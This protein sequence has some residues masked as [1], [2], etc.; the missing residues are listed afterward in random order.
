[1]AQLPDTDLIERARSACLNSLTAA[2]GETRTPME[3][4]GKPGFAPGLVRV[5]RHRAIQRILAAER[6]TAD[7]HSDA[8]C[9]FLA[10]R[11]PRDLVCAAATPAAS[12]AAA[13][14]H[15]HRLLAGPMWSHAMAASL[16]HAAGVAWAPQPGQPAVLPG[17]YLDGVAWSGL[18]LPR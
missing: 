7:L 3:Q 1:E 11:L 5:L 15:L 17:A 10:L 6:I 2:N 16:L 4:L 9:D 13:L 18:Q 8:D 14:D 12:D